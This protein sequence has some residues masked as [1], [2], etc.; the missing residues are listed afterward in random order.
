[1]SY[2]PFYLLNIFYSHGSCFSQYSF[3]I[4]LIFASISR[5]SVVAIY[6]LI[7]PSSHCRKLI[8]FRINY[9][10]SWVMNYFTL[11]PIIIYETLFFFAPLL[12]IPC[13]IC[14]QDT[15]PT[16]PTFT[17]RSCHPTKIFDLSSSFLFLL[18]WKKF[19]PDSLIPRTAILWNRLLGGCFPRSIAFLIL[20]PMSRFLP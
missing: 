10:D 9:V 13:R 15:V 11:Q 18:V 16:I 6:L 17:S 14:K 7:Q 5:L 2:I 20:F 19:Y 3:R 1:M 12:L 8:A 4:I